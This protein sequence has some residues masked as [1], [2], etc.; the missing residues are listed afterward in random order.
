M[1]R[2]SKN[3]LTCILTYILN[4]IFNHTVEHA[5]AK[6]EVLTQKLADARKEVAKIKAQLGDGEARKEE[7]VCVCVC[8][9]TELLCSTLQNDQGAAGGWGG[10]EGGAGVWEI[11]MH[12][13]GL[14]WL[15]SDVTSLMCE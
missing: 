11:V 1:R 4:H 8:V 2:P 13:E 15:Q 10:E 6:R 12:N 7:Q 9:A 5:E 3:H 14:D